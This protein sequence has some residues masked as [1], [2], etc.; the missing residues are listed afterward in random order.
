MAH[1]SEGHRFRGD[2][3]PHAAARREIVAWAGQTT[4]KPRIA[5]MARMEEA[6]HGVFPFPIR[7]IGVIRGSIC[8]LRHLRPDLDATVSAACPV[9]FLGAMGGL[10]AL[11]GGDRL[12]RSYAPPGGSVRQ[13]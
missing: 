3:S 8:R 6:E 7:A 10:A 12:K 1:R 5:R 4:K 2:P 9:R 13:Y 11:A